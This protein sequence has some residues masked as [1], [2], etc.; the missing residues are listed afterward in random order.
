MQVT[1]KVQATSKAKTG[2][3]GKTIATERKEYCMD[4]ENIV[5]VLK[6]H[7]AGTLFAGFKF[8]DYD[9][10]IICDGGYM[11]GYPDDEEFHFWFDL[12]GKTF[13]VE[14]PTLTDK[15]DL[16]HFDAM[17]DVLIQWYDT[18]G[19]A[20]DDVNA[21]DIRTK[22][23]VRGDDFLDNPEKQPVYTVSVTDL[24]DE[25]DTTPMC[26]CR[27]YYIADE[28]IA[29]AKKYAQEMAVSGEVLDIKVFAGEY[30]NVKTG[31][32]YGETE[33]VFSATNA[34]PAAYAYAR[35]RMHY[36]STEADYY[37]R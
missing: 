25:T 20:E 6:S 31:D 21:H 3:Y 24:E 18:A 12:F 4:Y 36:V 2:F 17:R 9:C 10:F 16:I 30:E 5:E 35:K 15:H 26:L 7:P 11:D 1:L 32:I 14:V 13:R 8:E 19:E 23:N 22:F 28:A 29:D 33:A 37:A 34:E 27:T